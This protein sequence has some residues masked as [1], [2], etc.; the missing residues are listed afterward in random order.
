MLK[1]AGV[2][3]NIPNNIKLIQ[4]KIDNKE[5]LEKFRELISRQWG[6][7]RVVDDPGILPK[8]KYKIPLNALESGYIQSFDAKVIGQAV[9]NLGGGR[10]KK[11]DTI[12]FAVGIETLKKIGDEVKEGEP[13]LY[14]HAN[15]E[16]QGLMQIETLR[17]SIKISKDPVEKEKEILDIIE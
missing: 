10:F 13:I 1:L 7:S 6:E 15:S 8:A 3:D 14:I 2:D 4:S 11:E 9:V 12:D 5:G 16:T 17:S